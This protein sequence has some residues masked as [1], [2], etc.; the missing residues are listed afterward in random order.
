MSEKSKRLMMIYTRLKSGPV[1]IEMLSAW[2]QKNDV[3]I[4]TRT[5]YRDLYDL[6][7]SFIPRNEKLVVTT[8]RIWFEFLYTFPKLP[9][10]IG[11]LFQKKFSGKTPQSLLSQI[12]QKP[13]WKIRRRSKIANYLHP[14]FRRNFLERA[15]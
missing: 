11:D 3:Q 1:T 8:Y 2:A 6:E 13:V 10:F 12:Q 5:F 14:F 4:S 15:P 9:S 7:S